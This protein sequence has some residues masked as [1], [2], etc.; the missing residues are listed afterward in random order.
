MDIKVLIVEDEPIPASYLQVIIEEE[1]DF[2]VV[3]IASSANEVYETLEKEHIDLIFMDIKINGPIN[4]ALLAQK[5]SKEYPHIYIIFMTAYSDDAYIEKAAES[6]ALGYLLK[7]YRPDEISAVLKLAKAK[8]KKED[9]KYIELIGGFRFDFNKKRLFFKDKEVTMPPKE[10]KFIQ[11]LAQNYNIVVDKNYIMQEL[12]L[13]DSALR[14]LIYRVR[15]MTHK[16]LILSEKRL[17]YKIA[18]I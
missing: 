9:K 16:D 8:I 17:G 2:K 6:K 18:T 1:K 13:N 14:T 15:Q 12:N 4:G 7:P 10:L 3:N 11:I 5:I